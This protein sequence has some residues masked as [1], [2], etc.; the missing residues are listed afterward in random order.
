MRRAAA[1]AANAAEAAAAARSRAAA[2]SVAGR[3]AGRGALTATMAR[4]PVAAVEGP[5]RPVRCGLVHFVD[6]MARY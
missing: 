4:R 6:S 5:W 3:L 1:Y 2:S